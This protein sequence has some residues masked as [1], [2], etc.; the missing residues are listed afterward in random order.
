MKMNKKFLAT[1]GNTADMC[2]FDI[3]FHPLCC[4]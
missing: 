1:D 4:V 3:V 2:N